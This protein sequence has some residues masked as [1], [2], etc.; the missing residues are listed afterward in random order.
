MVGKNPAE[1]A[2][3]QQ[4]LFALNIEGVQLITE[5]A[6]GG[7]TLNEGECLF[8]GHFR[9]PPAIG[10]PIRIAANWLQQLNH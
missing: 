7:E 8:L 10:Q 4:R 3:R 1:A 9:A 6:V 2:L 5:F